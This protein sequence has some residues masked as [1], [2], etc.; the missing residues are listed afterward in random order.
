MRSTDAGDFRILRLLLSE[1]RM[2]VG[3]TLVVALLQADL[4][5]GLRLA[6]PAGDHKGGPYR[7]VSLPAAITG[8]VG[9]PVG[10]P[11]GGS[12]ETASVA[13][14]VSRPARSE[15]ISSLIG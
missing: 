7:F 6:L 5:D 4:M 8:P 9:R 1:V 15:G 11:P 10:E 12:S 2:N 13:S 14:G 3:A